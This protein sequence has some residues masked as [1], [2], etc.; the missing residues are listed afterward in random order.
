MPVQSR[1][2]PDNKSMARFLM[3]T[4]VGTPA[5]REA[6]KIKAKAIATAP[7]DA[8]RND[9]APHY[10]DSFE[11]KRTVVTIS[12][13]GHANPRQSAEVSNESAHAAAVEFGNK[14]NG[15]R[16][17]HVLRRAAGVGGEK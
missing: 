7:F 3:T 9:D 11:V 4:D 10:V 2:V 13:G 6:E 14:A 5:V 16:G 15:G 8:V 17:Q 12:D 1:Y